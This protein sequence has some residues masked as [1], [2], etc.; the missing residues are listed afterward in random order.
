MRVV[1]SGAVKEKNRGAMAA[2]WLGAKRSAVDQRTLG[3]DLSRGVKQR[4]WSDGCYQVVE[5]ASKGGLR[6]R[7]CGGGSTVERCRSRSAGGVMRWLARQGLGKEHVVGCQAGLHACAVEDPS[8]S[9]RFGG[10]VR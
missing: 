3:H 2:Y 5:R 10:P 8:G 1:T 4:G 9:G 7:A 6:Q